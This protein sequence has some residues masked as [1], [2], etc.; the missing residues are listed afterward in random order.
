MSTHQ[1]TAEV[2]D[3]KVI[4]STLWIFAMLNYL[5]CDVMSLMDPN[6]LKQ[7]LAGNVGGVQLTPGFFLGAAVL[8]EIPTAMVLVS[9]V[10]GY[11]ANRW[12]NLIAGAI[13]TV[14]QFSSLFFG[15]LPSVYYL[16]FS[17]VEIASTL[18]IVGYAWTW[19][20]PEGQPSRIRY[21]IGSN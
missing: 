16:F 7:Y 19:P 14:V 17:V 12:A 15:S 21:N 11:R 1:K 20:S 8:M 2:K 18:F 4:L 6:L 3:R 9:R 5:Y 13:M 10:Q